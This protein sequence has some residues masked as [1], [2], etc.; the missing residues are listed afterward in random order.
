MPN[1]RYA[2]RRNAEPLMRPLRSSRAND[3]E[4]KG[5][6]HCRFCGKTRELAGDEQHGAADMDAFKE[7]E[8]RLRCSDCGQRTVSVE[9]MFHPDWRTTIRGKRRKI[10]PG[11]WNFL[12]AGAKLFGT[13]G[14]GSAEY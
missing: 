14:A 12:G 11:L 10:R 8:R 13:K 6:A 3:F 9:P 5:R 1:V 2:D 4:I 7:L